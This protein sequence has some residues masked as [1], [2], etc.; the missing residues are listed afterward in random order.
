MLWIFSREKRQA[1][2]LIKLARKT[3][4]RMDELL[5]QA[6]S[7]EDRE[8][9]WNHREERR[10]HLAEYERFFRG[11]C[12]PIELE[13]SHPLRHCDIYRDAMLDELY[14]LSGSAVQFASYLRQ[15]RA[16]SSKHRCPR[17][18]SA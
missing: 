18:E 9:I 8:L 4:A 10:A 14:D 11:E 7:V 17:G 1:R 5:A 15:I 3:I 6:T 12:T 13:L 2:S 16:P